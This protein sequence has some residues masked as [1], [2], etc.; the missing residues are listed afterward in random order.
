[1]HHLRTMTRMRGC[2]KHGDGMHAARALH[3]LDPPEIFHC[4]AAKIVEGH[5]PE[6]ITCLPVLT[7]RWF[8]LS[9]TRGDYAPSATCINM[10]I[11]GSLSRGARYDT[12]GQMLPFS[13]CL[14][15]VSWDLMHSALWIMTNRAPCN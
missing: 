3:H 6:L 9:H 8:L 13:A 7:V 5:R 15:P 2:T 1:V 12:C 14:V 11:C 10:H 4:G